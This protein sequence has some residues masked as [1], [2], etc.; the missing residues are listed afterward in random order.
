LSS[1]ATTWQPNLP[2]SVSLSGSN[3]W[4]GILVAAFTAAGA[5]VGTW[6]S[7]SGLQGGSFLTHTSAASKG[8]S[9][10][11][12]WTPPAAGAGSITFKAFVGTGYGPGAHFYLD[13]QVSQFSGIF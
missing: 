6:S 5:H 13:N 11:L 9:A 3:T 8:P 12:T 7:A 1:V 10:T 4:A 2:L